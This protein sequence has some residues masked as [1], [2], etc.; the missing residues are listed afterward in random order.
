MNSAHATELVQALFGESSDALFLIEAETA[1]IAD[2]NAAAESLSGRDRNALLGTPLFLLFQTKHP[3]GIEEIAKA[4]QARSLYRAAEGF[5]FLVG[6]GEAIPVE[7]TLRPLGDGPNMLLLLKDARHRQQLEQRAALAE[8]ELALILNT[9]SAAVWCAERD[10]DTPL[11][12]AGEGLVGWHY[13]YLSSA[14]ERVTGCPLQFFLD[15]PHRFAEI[16]HPD[17]RQAVLS[18]RTAFLLS[19]HTYF[20]MELRIVGAD[21]QERWVRSDLHATRDA[22]GRAVRLDGVL[23]DISRP[24]IAELSLRESR[25][26]LTRLLD[27][28][29]NG[30]LILDLAGHISFVNPAAVNLIGLRSEEI[31]DRDWNDLP[32]HADSDGPEKLPEFV[33]QT[34]QSSELTLDRRD[35]RRVTL[36]LS[37]APLR[38]DVGRVTGVVVTLF[39]LSQ[40]KRAEEAVRRSEERYRRLFERNLA[41]VSL[42]TI[43]GKFID[44]NPAFAYIFGYGSPGEMRDVNGRDLYF[45]LAEREAKLA[46]LSADGQ[47]GNLETCRRRKDGSEVWILE[48]AMLV[49]NPGGTPIIETTIVDITEHKKAERNLAREHAL[50]LS[51][52]NSIP[53]LIFFKDRAG[54][55]LGCN[56]AFEEY[57]GLRE[58]DVL[59]HTTADLYSPEQA[60]A[61]AEEDRQVYATGQPLRLE[62]VLKTS[63]GERQVELV[64]NPMIDADGTI[65][66]LLGIGRDMTERRRLEEQ[67]RQAGK[68]DAIGQLAGGVA[69]DFNNLLTII[70]GNMSMAR[71]ILVGKEHIAALLAD[72]E[73]AAQRAAELTNQL[74]GF[75]RRHPLA[76]QPLDLNQCVAETLQMLRRTIDP[77]VVLESRPA[78][79]LG[80]IEADAGQMSQVLMNLSLNARDAM[81]EGG[82]LL[83]TTSNIVLGSD[84]ALGNLEARS[85]EFVR[86]RLS[87]NGRGIA[88]EVR[89]R[90]F[91]PFFT[92]KSFGKGTGLGLAVVFGIIRQHRGW[93]ECHS[94]PGRGTRFDIYL[95]RSSKAVPRPSIIPDGLPIAGSETILLVDDEPMIRELGRA[96]LSKQG[97]NV[98]LA[99]DGAVGVDV[100]RKHG[101]QID[102]VILDLSMPNMSGKEALQHLRILDPHVRVVFASGYSTDQFEAGELDGVLGFISKPYRPQDLTR[103]IRAALDRNKEDGAPSVFSAEG[104]E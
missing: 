20:S 44:A 5:D 102:L 100:Y 27:T 30:I 63:I 96:I 37:A 21:G 6:A 43:D 61:M 33:Y 24:K 87:D 49:P 10:P 99:E 103:A 73:Q 39:D 48:N 95:P 42:Y 8:T 15:G 82:R 31:L 83:V 1:H 46:R 16:V 12:K 47:I 56:H 14:T 38:D 101:A 91:E 86:L 65:L 97:Y 75:A 90:I 51:L 17:D 72:S 88:P 29:A 71:S 76:M 18:E 64:L 93:I 67:L 26:W 80:T 9:V 4:L 45:D 66:G 60:A 2:A 52:L 28:N 7:L 36:S 98:L 85:G 13:R 70:L 92:T 41:G 25:N 54:H 77:R 59:E 50:L 23:T 35:G 81:P 58:A 79:D 32:W 104:V 68:M 84:A 3:N 55:Y 74:L 53:D 62:K 19:P 57:S 94:E 34:L 40:R 69:H 78:P 89:S 22:Q 11:P